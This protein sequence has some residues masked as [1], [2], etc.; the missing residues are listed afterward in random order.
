MGLSPESRYGR[1]T[2][3]V[4]ERSASRYGSRDEPFLKAEAELQ[5]DL[6]MAPAKSI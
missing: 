4:P 2:M 6:T 3:I 5:D 1:D